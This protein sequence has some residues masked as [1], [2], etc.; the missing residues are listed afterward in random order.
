MAKWTFRQ[1][2]QTSTGYEERHLSV[3]GPLYHGSRA[4]RLARDTQITP[5]RR[6]NSWGDEGPRSRN[7][8]FTSTLDVAKSYAAQAG[9]EVYE[10]EPTGPFKTDYRGDEFKT[11]HPLRVIRKVTD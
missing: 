5:G 6:T 2:V 1:T 10:V 3:D 7:V 4:K 9:G 8:Y 11:E